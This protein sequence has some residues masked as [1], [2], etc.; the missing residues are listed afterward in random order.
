MFDFIRQHKKIMQILLIILIFPSFV[1]FGIDGYK[2][3]NEK[4]DVVASVDGIDITKQEWEK[5]H[6]S[7]IQR[8]RASMPNIDVSMFDTPEIKYGVLERLVQ[9]KVL[10][11]SVNKLNIKVSDQKVAQSIA[12][13][14]VLASIKKPDGTLD[15]ERYRQLLAAQ[16]MSPEMFEN[17]MRSDVAVK[18]VVTG[19]TQSSLTFPS[20]MQA[21][22][23][24][25]LQ[26][27]EVQIAIFSASDYLADAKPTDD[28]VLKFFNDNKEDYKSL[29]S[30]DIEYV[31]L[32]Q[33]AVEKT[34]TV[35]DADLKSYFDQNQ[36]NLA[37]K[38]ERRA[39]HIL[40]NAPK[41]LNSSDMA[42]AKEKP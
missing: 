25:F 21:A 5:S 32:S 30:A 16:G 22:L 40:I 10:E 41:D 14:E 42:K 37:A 33:D 11:A 3:F 2:G 35:S 34:I 38:E 17:R 7:E 31:V 1:L 8:M 36:S 28:E 27:R 20:Q 26:Q 24:A 19:V 23:D 6:E 4:G 13:M 18:Q 15:L 12:E 9:S 39:S 29:E